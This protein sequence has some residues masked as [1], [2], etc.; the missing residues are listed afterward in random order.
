LSGKSGA[1]KGGMRGGA[2]K[3]KIDNITTGITVNGVTHSSGVIIED[4]AKN[5]KYFFHNS[6]MEYAYLIYKS[7]T[8]KRWDGYM[9]E[10]DVNDDQTDRLRER[11]IHPDN[12]IIILQ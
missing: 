6:I 12:E 5:K 11:L 1:K 7:H 9:Q 2:N 4:L 3:F 8:G 10:F